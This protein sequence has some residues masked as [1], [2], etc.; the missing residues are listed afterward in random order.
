MNEFYSKGINCIKYGWWCNDSFNDYLRW[1]NDVS[2]QKA[3][4]YVDLIKK[5]RENWE[6]SC[7]N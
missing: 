1:K 2:M 3:F 5:T 6:R 7:T 4:T